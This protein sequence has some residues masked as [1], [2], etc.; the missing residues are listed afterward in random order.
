[1][2][3]TNK[4]KLA[5]IETNFIYKCLGQCHLSIKVKKKNIPLFHGY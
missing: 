4:I 1:M 2:Y 3:D 5:I